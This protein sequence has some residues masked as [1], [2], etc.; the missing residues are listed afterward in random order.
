MTDAEASTPPDLD[1]L[2]ARARL[3]R[4]GAPEVLW[5]LIN[6]DL[7]VPMVAGTDGTPQP[8]VTEVDGVQFMSVF[9]T[10]ER[11][12][13]VGHLADRVV[14]LA[15][16]R[17]LMGLAPGSGLTVVAADGGFEVDPSTV[18]QLQQGLH[19]DEG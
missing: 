1:E 16:R 5:S 14:T 6:S 17:V 19:E 7:V 12:A 4:A 18:A 9:T 2:I 11:A 15:G 13:S 3:G 10:L 8:V